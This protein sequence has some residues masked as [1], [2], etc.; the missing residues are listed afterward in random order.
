MFGF[1]GSGR[2]SHRPSKSSVM[3]GL[4]GPT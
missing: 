4:S 2:N 3:A 1:V